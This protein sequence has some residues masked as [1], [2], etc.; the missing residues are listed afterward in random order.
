MKYLRYLL[1]L[2]IIALLVSCN[3]GSNPGEG[4]NTPEPTPSQTSAELLKNWNISKGTHF[5]TETNIQKALAVFNEDCAGLVTSFESENLNSGP[6]DADGGEQKPYRLTLGTAS[7]SGSITF[8]FSKSIKKMTITA[9]GYTKYEYA[10]SETSK[11]TTTLGMENDSR[12][13]SPNEDSQFV[14]ESTG[15]VIAKF[16]TSNVGATG[17]RAFIKSI[18]V[19]W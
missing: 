3:N 17:Y 19:E 6:N 13:V 9:S 18:V 4:G 2:S 16:E 14:I 7:A 8:N 15:S 5:D 10:S 12:V 11:L 1:P